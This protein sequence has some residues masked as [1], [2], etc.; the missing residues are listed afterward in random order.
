MASSSENIGNDHAD[1]YNQLWHECA[2][3]TI[4]VPQIGDRV[5]Y[6][7]Q[8][9]FEMDTDDT[10]IPTYHVPSKILCKVVDVELKVYPE[11]DEVFAEIVLLQDSEEG[12]GAT[13][14]SVPQKIP[15]NSFQKILTISD[16]STHGGCGLPKFYVEKTFPPLDASLDQASQDLVAKDLHGATWH[17][18]HIYRGNPKRHMLV[19][20]WNKFASEKKLKA[21]DTCIFIR[22]L[23]QNEIYIGIQRAVRMQK[24]PI[25]L[26]GSTMRH[27][28][29][30]GAS[31]AMETRCKFPVNYHPRM[32][33]S[34]FIVSYD[35]VMEALKVN[36][37]PEM[38]FE[39]LVDG[40]GDDPEHIPKKFSGII[41]AKEDIDPARWPNSEWRCLKVHWDVTS[42][43]YVLPFRVSPWDIRPLGLDVLHMQSSISVDRKRS[44]PFEPMI[45]NNPFS[46]TNENNQLDG[47]HGQGLTLSIANT[48]SS[49]RQHETNLAEGKQ[50]QALS[51]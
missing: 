5:F 30:L 50:R 46:R 41:I 6:F 17:F 18:R 27:G 28:V 3:L 8:G 38:G 47:L 16:A 4:K 12:E 51:L 25:D 20:G 11:S 2:G 34:P 26:D 14:R 48:G 39:M 33:G 23:G 49:S 32:S 10:T 21:G 13:F 19:N 40:G 15:A 35:K 29:L 37:L 9:H 1:L 22:G 44:M 42:R 43:S 7:P 31:V 24:I 45:R 36:Y